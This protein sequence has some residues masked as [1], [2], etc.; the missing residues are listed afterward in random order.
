M[1]LP[2]GSAFQ[3]F[4]LSADQSEDIKKVETNVQENDG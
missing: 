2:G 1:I 4:D 3:G